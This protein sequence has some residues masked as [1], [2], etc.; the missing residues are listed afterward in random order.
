MSWAD[1][2]A[3][4]A[5][6]LA[7][8]GRTSLPLKH[9]FRDE[10]YVREITVPAD[11]VFIGRPHVHGHICKLISG[12]LLLLTEEKRIQLTAPYQ[13]HTRPGYQMVFYTYTEVVGET[14]HFNPDK[15]RDINE[16]ETE[17]FG[18]AE[19]VLQ[20]GQMLERKMLEAK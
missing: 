16:L 11:T 9:S 18:L 2:I 14:W 19:A 8:V 7:P 15:C 4:L 12:S 20:R 3:Y 1:K 5:H 6:K 10:W 13:I 17:H